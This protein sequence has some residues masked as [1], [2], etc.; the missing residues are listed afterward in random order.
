MAGTHSRFKTGANSIATA[1]SRCSLSARWACVYGARDALIF[2]R[3]A[4]E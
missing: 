3:V 4:S 1:L 2:A